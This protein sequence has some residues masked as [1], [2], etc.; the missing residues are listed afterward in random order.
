MESAARCLSSKG[1][2]ATPSRYRDA[3][4]VFVGEI[5]IEKCKVGGEHPHEQR[6]MHLD[7]FCFIALLCCLHNRSSVG[8]L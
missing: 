2:R 6:L 4:S 1:R 8:V 7:R 3:L 5:Y